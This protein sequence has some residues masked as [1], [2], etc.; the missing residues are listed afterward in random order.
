MASLVNAWWVGSAAVADEVDADAA[1]VGAAP[2]EGLLW[3]EAG[4]GWVFCWE[5]RL[6][7]GLL[8]EPPS[9]EPP[10]SLS[11]WSS[12]SMAQKCSKISGTFG[13]G[14]EPT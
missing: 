1:P 2:L 10:S 4:S 11:V 12:K 7:E 13:I 8:R 5:G 3:E 14:F 6:I 9:S